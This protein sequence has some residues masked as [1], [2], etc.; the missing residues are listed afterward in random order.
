MDYELDFA[1]NKFN[2]FSSTH[3]AGNV[4]YWADKAA[5]IPYTLDKLGLPIFPIELDGKKV[6][7]ALRLGAAG[8]QLKTDVSKTLYGFDERSLGIRHDTSASGKAVNH[9][10]A[11][12]MTLP[13]LSVTNADVQLV[14]GLA[15]SCNLATSGPEHSVNY[16]N[17]FGSPPLTLGLDVLR[18]LRLYFAT[19]EHIVYV[20]EA[21]A[22]REEAGTR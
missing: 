3:C 9:Y 15:K 7:A 22:A 21:E 14:P 19:E 20:T 5:A 10:R 16:Q 13:G 2:L 1:H 4:V 6:S 18:H 8:T 11:M 12:K 17:C